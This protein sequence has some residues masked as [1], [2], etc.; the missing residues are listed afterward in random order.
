MTTL[1]K[2]RNYVAHYSIL[3]E[4][5]NHRL[6]LR[7]IHRGLQFQ[8]KLWLRP[9]IEINTQM[10]EQSKNKF[11]E[12]IF[13]LMNNAIYGKCMQ[14]RQKEKDVKAI[15]KWGGRFG[16]EG[17]LFFEDFLEFCRIPETEFRL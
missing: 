13:K 11:E 17:Y 3:A 12:M 2:K 7:K 1:Y 5:L 8:Q 16:M 6:R 15:T 14:K 10:R 9:Y 4:A